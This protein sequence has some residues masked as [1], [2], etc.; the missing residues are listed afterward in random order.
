MNVGL[1]NDVSRKYFLVEVFSWLILKKALLVP[2]SRSINQGLTSH[3]ARS[4]FQCGHYVSR[5]QVIQAT[6][7]PLGD[8]RASSGVAVP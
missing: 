8:K 4:S 7:Q 5:W 2:H 3:Q 1:S 6:T